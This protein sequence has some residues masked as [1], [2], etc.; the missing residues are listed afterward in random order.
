MTPRSVLTCL[1]ALILTL[2]ASSAQAQMPNPYGAPITLETAK[3]AA[4][5][6]VAEARKNNWPMSVAITDAAGDLVYFEKMDGNQTGSVN[7]SVDKARSAA[8][9]K[10]PTKVWADLVGAGGDNLRLMVLQGIVPSP[11]GI[12]L[13]VDGKIVGAIGLSGGTGPQ[14]A[15]CAQ[16]GADAL[17]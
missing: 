12:P 7:L 10:R 16:A 13:V 9:Y 5:G 14:D 4:A 11:G 8:C 6:A 1:I 2:G 3:K 17:K 15:Q